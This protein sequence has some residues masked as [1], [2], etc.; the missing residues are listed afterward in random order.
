MA[1]AREMARRIKREQERVQR[2]YDRTT[3]EMGLTALSFLI[4]GALGATLGIA[5]DSAYALIVGGVSM[6]VG[7]TFG[8][9]WAI[10]D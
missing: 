3:H 6:A 7:G 9:V 10:R 2:E 4:L 5:G 8:I 1:A